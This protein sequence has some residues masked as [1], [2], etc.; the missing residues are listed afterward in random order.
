MAKWVWLAIVLAA[1]A[2]FTAFWIWRPAEPPPSGPI[3]SGASVVAFATPP[4]GVH[5]ESAEDH[6]DIRNAVS[7]TDPDALRVALRDAGLT[8]LWVE[9]RP[10]G[11]W[12]PELPLEQRFSAA[13]VVGGFRGELLTAQGLLYFI[14]PTEV[15]VVLADEVLAKAAR[16]ILAGSDPPALEDF[17]QALA[18][19]QA[20]EVLVMLSGERGP[21]LWRSAKADSIAQGLI[22]A[23]VA[24]R[25]RWEER[26]AT[27]GGPLDDRLGQLDVQVALLFDDGTIDSSAISLIDA[28]V[29]PV[30]GVAYEQP[31]RWRYLLPRATV[32]A[33]SPTR[34]FQDLFEDNGL[35]KDSFDRADIR[36]YRIRMQMLS[37]DQ[38][39]ADSTDTIVI[40]EVVEG[41]QSGSSEPDTSNGGSGSEGS[42]TTNVVPNP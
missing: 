41:S 11:P 38:G 34:A 32:A 5:W 39:L 29:K 10:N 19:R 31:G 6:P 13:G 37:V 26:S 12:E 42:D 24:A 40:P 14:E 4:S 8:G 15:P 23:S 20:V 36:L 27:M 35:P 2:F 25:S 1:V 21:L 30:H 18:Q 17:P 33:G 16:K 28:L 3:P 9:A 22:T 7:G